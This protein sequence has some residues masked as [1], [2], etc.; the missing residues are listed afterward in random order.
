MTVDTNEKESI[1]TVAVNRTATVRNRDSGKPVYDLKAKG[2]EVT[3]T[4]RAQGTVHKEDLAFA[5][6][7]LSG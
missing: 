1:V 3:I 4:R 2:D 5:V 6:K 7:E